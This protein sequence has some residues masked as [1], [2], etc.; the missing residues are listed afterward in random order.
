MSNNNS[1][2]NSV[3]A[4]S[5]P[6]PFLEL[7]ADT[8]YY[9]D[10]SSIDFENVLTVWLTLTKSSSFIK[11][12]K[13]LE[14]IS[15]RVVNRNLILLREQREKAAVAAAEEAAASSAGTNPGVVAA[16]DNSKEAAVPNNNKPN[17][18]N[19]IPLDTLQLGENDF[20]SL[21]AISNHRDGSRQPFLQE[22]TPT[23]KTG[24]GSTTRPKLR[25]DYTSS[26]SS[27][28]RRAAL[29]KA[30]PTSS[31]PTPTPTPP[32]SSSY[33]SAT[34]TSNNNVHN[35]SK[36][37]YSFKVKTAGQQQQ[38]QQQRPPLRPS[39]S[40]QKSEISIQNVG[41]EITEEIS[42][43]ESETENHLHEH[44]HRHKQEHEQEQAQEQEDIIY[45]QPEPKYA[46]GIFTRKDSA[47][48]KDEE[49]AK[50]AKQTEQI[51]EELNRERPPMLRTSTSTSIVRGFSPSDI[52]INHS[53]QSTKKNTPE[54][55]NNNENGKG[56][57]PL[58]PPTSSLFDFN[59]KDI[60]KKTGTNNNSKEPS[61]VYSDGTPNHKLSK[62]LSL[63][64]N[65]GMTTMHNINNVNPNNQNNMFFIESS[66]SPAESDIVGS[67]DHMTLNKDT[68]EKHR[69][70]QENG[71]HDHIATGNVADGSIA[72]PG[73]D[74]SHTHSNSHSHNQD[75]TNTGLEGKKDEIDSKIDDTQKQHANGSPV[76]QQQS[77]VSLF[78]QQP[79]NQLMFS[80]EESLSDDSEWSS[81]SG[82]ED[83]SD[84]YNDSEYHK[85]K[86]NEEQLKF[87]KQDEAAKRPPIR[88][89]LL[90]GLFLNQM[91]DHP[92]DG[93][94]PSSAQVT[95]SDTQNQAHPAQKQMQMRAQSS[96]VIPVAKP[97]LTR[98]SFST[99]YEGD[100]K[101]PPPQHIIESK[102]CLEISSTKDNNSNRKKS[103]V[104]TSQTNVNALASSVSP[105]SKPILLKESSAVSSAGTLSYDKRQ[106]SLTRLMSKSALNLTSY[107]AKNR[108]PSHSHQSNAPP[109][110]STLLPTAL[111][112]HMFIPNAHQ[113]ARSKLS[114]VVER[115]PS[116]VSDE[117]NGGNYGGTIKSDDGIIDANNVEDASSKNGSSHDRKQTHGTDIKSSKCPSSVSL[118]SLHS[119]QN[120]KHDSSSGLENEEKNTNEN[121][122][123]ISNGEDLV[124]EDELHESSLIP[125]SQPKQINYQALPARSN[126]LQHNQLQQKVVIPGVKLSPRSTRRNMIA[127]ELSESLRKSILWD[128]KV[129]KVQIDEGYDPEL[130]PNT[131]HH[132]HH[133]HHRA[134][135]GRSLSDK[136]QVP[137]LES[138]ERSEGK[139]LENGFDN[140]HRANEE[141]TSRNISESKALMNGNNNTGTTVASLEDENEIKSSQENLWLDSDDNHLDYHA[142]GW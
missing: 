51:N 86:W 103:S 33:S 117:N 20:K 133:H 14:N 34:N 107:F 141:D 122:G 142:K 109:T 39:H 116:P 12:G 56:K 108:R 42:G 140:S 16:N 69:H 132:H 38:Q 115:S 67:I 59:N 73:N 124:S 136:N 138:S 79:T 113:L 87:A 125:H 137:S 118:S 93:S 52:S 76:S 114:S 78:Y 85:Q 26:S 110:A 23:R 32:A 2:N 40:R 111:A 80:S 100:Q 101:R 131:H 46:F 134:D 27:S 123:S 57:S 53:I 21:I 15:W 10:Q 129:F 22:L 75:R 106:S 49:Q 99:N 119:Y 120:H 29:F 6:I 74:K 121:N 91:N 88:R 82:S 83:N 98:R 63:L 9:L 54:F 81:I 104:V 127:T 8:L 72:H 48:L 30:T 68:L 19:S 89:S 92:H 66:P 35:N 28:L 65:L 97:S 60:K 128:R 5:R 62:K 47:T 36:S 24:A 13:R 11:N 135:H 7:S 71:N 130:E 139:L 41:K 84:D 31:T 95:A 102:S 45:N 4:K 50:V 37:S 126:Q 1:N 3:G 61:K 105:L 55:V 70:H 18:K 25:H 17:G 94:E 64:T 77:N 90:S 58:L 112:T 96:T 43:S 44:E